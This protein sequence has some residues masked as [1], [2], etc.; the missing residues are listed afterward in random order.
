M[1]AANSRAEIERKSERQAAAS[2]Q[3]AGTGK[4]STVPCFAYRPDG[5][6]DPVQAAEVRQASSSF[7]AGAGIKTIA[8]DSNRRGIV[9]TRGAAWTPKG[10]RLILR[11]RR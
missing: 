2:V 1:S 5:S 9:N 10:V 4:V 11:N 7:V 8:D 6:I 3:A